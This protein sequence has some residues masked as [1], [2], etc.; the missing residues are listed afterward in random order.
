MEFLN[1]LKILI[2]LS[3][4]MF[5]GI[6]DFVDLF[7]CFNATGSFKYC[8]KIAMLKGKKNSHKDKCLSLKNSFNQKN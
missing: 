6:T 5:S 2:T 8:F 3:S 4:E 7:F 1:E